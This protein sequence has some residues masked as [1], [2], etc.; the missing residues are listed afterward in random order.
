MVVLLKKKKLIS[1]FKVLFESVDF[2]FKE[3][4]YNI[5]THNDCDGITSG[6][7]ISG[8]LKNI[9]KKTNLHILELLDIET[10][11]K[12]EEPF[13]LCDL[14]SS[15]KKREL[16]EN[17][18]IDHHEVFDQKWEEEKR[19]INPH[20]YLKNICQEFSASL[21]IF[22]LTI[23]SDE[24][25]IKNWAPAYL[26]MIGDRVEGQVPKAINEFFRENDFLEEK[27]SI[28]FYGIY[29]RNLKQLSM[30]NTKFPSLT[31]IK[32]KIGSSLPEELLGQ[33]R[34]VDLTKEDQEIIR[35][36]TGIDLVKKNLFKKKS[37]WEEYSRDP[38]EVVALINGSC[39]LRDYNSAT[40]FLEKPKT[41]LENMKNNKKKYSHMLKKGLNLIE[42]GK[43]IKDNYKNFDF[44]DFGDK[45]DYLL[46]GVIGGMVDLETV[47]TAANYPGGDELKVS[48]RTKREDIDIGKTLKTLKERVVIKNFGGHR[49]AGGVRI[50][51]KNLK[52]FLEEN[53]KLMNKENKF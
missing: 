52:I 16:G 23:Y 12:L 2:S 36:F 49:K 31:E 4:F 44:F 34:W 21:V 24:K 9:G 18:I 19:F 32:E 28:D 11:K 25:N 48:F 29:S 14:G 26:G 8:F 22:L 41:S 46:I 50:D 35:I 37:I 30:Y 7:L 40:I 13:I 45:I 15:M 10:F 51:R 17:M 38:N 27:N 1:F 20:I 42:F 39:R 53:D 43:V 5:Y 6:F 3:N 33:I 47:V